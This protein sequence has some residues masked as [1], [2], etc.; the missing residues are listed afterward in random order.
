MGN[1]LPKAQNF[2]Q[3]HQTEVA[4][5]DDDLLQ[6]R[7]LKLAVKEKMFSWSGDNFKIKTADGTE[8]LQITGRVFTMRDRMVLYS[9]A[10]APLAVIMRMMFTIVPAF[11]IYAF[12]PRVQ[13]QRESGE[14]EDNR[15]LYSWAMVE[16]EVC[17]CMQK[18]YTLHM[19]VGNDN[20]RPAYTAETPGGM[21]PG[22][23]V[24]KGGK[25]CCHVDR[26]MFQWEFANMY[27][28]TISP[29]IDPA[30]MVC[31]TAIQDE[32]KEE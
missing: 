17:T 30:L 20:F 5:L 10:G 27:A 19:A 21:T 8:F 14:V 15:P 22:F 3:D 13:G 1:D 28:V 11:Y 31:F 32:M 7:V 9:A 6:D 18:R 26:E 29:G 2:L 16:K 23:T 25:G 4:N 24:Q 12:K